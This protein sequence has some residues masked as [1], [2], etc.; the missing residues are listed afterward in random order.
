[1]E[2]KAQIDNFVHACDA[3]YNLLREGLSVSEFERLQL[4]GCTTKLRSL[5]TYLEGDSKRHAPGN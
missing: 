5:V 2:H 1:M 4:K 3:M